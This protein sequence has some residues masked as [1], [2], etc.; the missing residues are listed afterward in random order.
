[1]PTVS[2]VEGNRDEEASARERKA[3]C[4]ACSLLTLGMEA[5]SKACFTAELSVMYETSLDSRAASEKDDSAE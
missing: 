5:K 3:S 1:M 2:L 4:L